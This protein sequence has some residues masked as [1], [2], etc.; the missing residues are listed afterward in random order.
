MEKLWNTVGAI[1]ISFGSAGAIVS[2]FVKFCSNKIAEKL[3]QK[4]QLTLDK[5][6][7]EFKNNLDKKNYVSKVRF[8]KEFE[9]YQ[10]LSERR[11]ELVFILSDFN[12]YID[13]Y[14]GR[15]EDFANH[16]KRQELTEKTFFKNEI[17]KLIDSYN[18]NNFSTRKFA[19]FIDEKM[20]NDISTLNKTCFEQ[21]NN[22]LKILSFFENMDY[23]SLVF[24]NN[25][26]KDEVEE[27]FRSFDFKEEI[28]ETFNNI[29][30]KQNEISN[31]SDNLTKDMRI[32]L[33]SLEVRS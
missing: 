24:K 8:D 17:S 31:M 2:A 5:E 6:L 30:E 19:P 28:E 11:L 23:S 16:V 10:E 27:F 32:Y 33:K 21:I 7:E 29:Q 18:K 25:V 12:Q 22:C 13:M 9:I 15:R 1:I 14:I 20:Y 4:Y 26:P 3:S